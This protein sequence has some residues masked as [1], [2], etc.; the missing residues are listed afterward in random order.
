MSKLFDW[1]FGQSIE[2]E[3]MTKELEDMNMQTEF[4]ANES[5][6]HAEDIADFAQESSSFF[7]N[8]TFFGSGFDGTDML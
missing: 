2:Q 4:Y 6:N 1:L 5:M 8:N 7:D 3:H